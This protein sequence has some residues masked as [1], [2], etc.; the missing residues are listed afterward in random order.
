[1]KITMKTSKTMK[2]FFDDFIIAKKAQGLADKTIK[3][4]QSQFRAINNHL[5]VNVPIEDITKSDLEKMVT[6]MRNS[7]L[8]ANSISTYVRILRV[9]LSWCNEEGITNLNMKPYKS[10]ETIKET[11]SD[12]ELKKLLKKPDLR[13]CNFA[14]YRSWVIVNLLLNNGCRAATIRNIQNQDVD[15]DNQVIYLRHTKNKKS[16]V[17]PLC[18]ELCSIIREYMRV[19]GGGNDEYLFPNESGEQ[20]KEYALRSSIARY[21]NRRGVQKTKAYIPF[22][23]LSRGNILLTAEVMRL[24]C[25]GY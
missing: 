20:L 10:E 2:E 15:L 3:S 13:K 17:I 8:A 5:D 16:Q 11:Y 9:F 25:N 24:R 6:S 18:S 7:N 12:G 23:I 4:Y 22:V 14:E 1:M 19:R 21:N